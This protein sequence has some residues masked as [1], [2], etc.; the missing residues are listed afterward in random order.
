[1]RS[2]G[3]DVMIVSDC[4]TLG[5]SVGRQLARSARSEWWAGGRP[6]RVPAAGGAGRSGDRRLARGAER[7]RRPGRSSRWHPWRRGLGDWRQHRGH[8]ERV[9]HAVL[10]EDVC[11]AQRGRG[12]GHPQRAL[13][14]QGL[15]RHRHHRPHRQVGSE[16]E[17]RCDLRQRRL[18]GQRV[19]RP[20][21]QPAE[22]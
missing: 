6:R 7:Q 18:P 15:H 5:G 4:Y 13:L 21:F 20:L 8:R 10:R 2:G 9:E 14:P 22:R 17:V 1:M 19:R 11:P 3:K 16:Q 12:R